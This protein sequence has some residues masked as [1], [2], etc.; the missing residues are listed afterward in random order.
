MPLPS[1][2]LFWLQLFIAPTNTTL[3]TVQAT[4]NP[5]KYKLAPNTTAGSVT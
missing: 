4:L 1:F 5:I 3:A 2:C